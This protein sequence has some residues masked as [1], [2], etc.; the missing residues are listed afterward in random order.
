MK[1]MN[2]STYSSR[3]ITAQIFL[4]IALLI[5]AA[6]PINVHGQEGTE[7]PEQSDVG[8]SSP[9]EESLADDIRPSEGLLRKNKRKEGLRMGGN[10]AQGA[11]KQNKPQADMVMRRQKLLEFT[12]KYLESVEDPYSAIGFACL[13]ILEHHRRAKTPD[14][15]VEELEAMLSKVSAQKARNVI[16]FGLRQAHENGKKRDRCQAMNKRI[17]E[18]NLKHIQNQKK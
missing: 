17:F 12:G 5:L 13:G 4:P 1:T 3:T 7:L 11:N 18:E 6:L 2:I 10:N 9:D 15:A 8:R 14:A 16:V